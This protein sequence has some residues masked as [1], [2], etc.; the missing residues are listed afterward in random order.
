[1]E[2]SPSRKNFKAS[3]AGSKLTSSPKL[4]TPFIHTHTTNPF[5]RVQWNSWASGPSC[6]WAK[7]KHTEDHRRL[8]I[9]HYHPG[10]LVSDH[11]WIPKEHMTSY[12][13]PTHFFLD[14]MN[15]LVKRSPCF[16][17]FC[18]TSIPFLFIYCTWDNL[19]REWSFLHLHIPLD[20]SDFGEQG[21]ALE[22]FALMQTISKATS[23][24]WTLLFF[25]WFIL[26]RKNVTSSIVCQIF[27]M[28]V[29]FKIDNTHTHKII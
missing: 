20:C 26:Y 1:M 6:C 24:H 10:T 11:T 23:L 16:K 9:L 5:C 21:N 7:L 27:Y 3:I 4:N 8:V 17:F 25:W 22:L 28:Y 18:H 2:S 29:L 15:L 12:M 19:P 14:A 13:F